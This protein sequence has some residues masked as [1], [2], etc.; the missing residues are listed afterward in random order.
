MKKNKAVFLDRDGVINKKVSVRDFVKN[1]KELVYFSGVIETVRKIKES[2]FL[3]IIISNQSGINRGIIRKENLEKI[4]EKL[5]KDLGVD[6][7]YYCPHLPEEN[8]NCRKPRNGLIQ[9]ALNDFNIDVKKSWMIGD[10][11]SDIIAGE[12]SGCRTFMVDSEKGL[13]QIA[14]MLNTLGEI[15]R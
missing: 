4:N 15:N 1:E 9:R 7:I 12:A 10:S 11:D 14:D 6:G 8:C 13:A 2:G 5:K 3:A